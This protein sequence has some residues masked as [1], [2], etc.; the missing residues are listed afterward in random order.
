MKVS[1]SVIT[2]NHEEFIAQ[3]VDSILRQE[4]NFDYEIVIGEDVSSD[5]TRE[6]VL[7]LEKRHPGKIR[8]LLQDAVDSERDRARGL[9]GKKNFVKTLQECRG[10]YVA[11]LDGDD[12]WTDSHKLQKQVDFLEQHP[13]CSLCFHNAEMFYD[14]GSQRSMN[15]RPADQKEISTV[16]DILAG[17]V[18]IP[19]TVMFRNNL[20]GALPES[21]DSVA[22]GDWMLFVLLAEHGTVGYLNEVMAAYRMHAGGIWSRLTAQQRVKE[23][24][25]TYK[26]INAYLNFK[27]DRVISEK[28]AELPKRQR[29]QQA[30]SCLDQYH[31]L[32]QKGEMKNGLRLLWQATHSAP[33]EVLRPRRLAAVLKNGLLGILRKNSLQN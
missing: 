25:H 14:D 33:L 22:N 21:F 15:L 28:I 27:Y 2:Y 30:R 29:E 12:Y 4:V 3:A 18:P 6:I 13:E 23:H 26:T 7:E 8:V 17:V 10:E 32:V 9:G 11:L 31:K 5:R 19:C 1:V 16:E 20:L 24:I